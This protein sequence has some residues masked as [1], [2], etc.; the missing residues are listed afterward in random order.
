M[1]IEIWSDVVCPF[2]YLGKRRLEQALAEFPGKGGVEI[3]WKSF[4]LH[5][6]MPRRPGLSLEQYLAERKGWSMAQ[7]R[8]GH[9]RLERAGA[10]VGLEYR[11]DKAVV[12]D[13]FDA[14]R[15]IHAAQA[16]GKGGALEER[17]FRAYFTEGMDIADAQVLQGLAQDVGMERVQ[18]VKVLADRDAFAAAVRADIEE[19]GRLGIGGVPF[20]VFDRRFAVSGAQDTETY[21]RAL[22]EASEE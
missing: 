10:E 14:H 22:A 2:C 19:A 16:E 7:I 3:E 11:F 18:A 21:R 1:H 13:T 4:Q 15:L 17:L 9:E 5:P 8:S 6:E 20:F 12:A